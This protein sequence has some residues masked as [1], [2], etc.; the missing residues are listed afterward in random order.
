MSLQ[1][2]NNS[3]FRVFQFKLTYHF[4]L[5]LLSGTWTSWILVAASE[6]VSLSFLGQTAFA[7]SP[8]MWFIPGHYLIRVCNSTFC[9]FTAC[10][11]RKHF[12]NFGILYTSLTLPQGRLHLT[13]FC[14]VSLLKLAAHKK[15]HEVF[16]FSENC[17]TIPSLCFLSLPENKL[18]ALCCSMRNDIN[19]G[20]VNMA[21]VD[22]RRK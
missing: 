7:R 21:T 18:K 12:K 17:K 20:S 16:N 4:P 5:H 10:N 19:V 2:W 15:T 9:C 1:S 22:R 14:G 6:I 13:C 11:K 3:W 8:L